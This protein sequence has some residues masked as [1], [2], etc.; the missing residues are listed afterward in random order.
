MFKGLNN[1]ISFEDLSKEEL[2]AFNYI[3]YNLYCRRGVDFTQY[4][5]KCL[6]RRVIV[7]M[8]DANCSSFVDFL[9]Y[10][11]SNPDFYDYLLDRITINVS[12]FFRNPET[13]EYV[14]K[15]VIPDIILRK[16]EIGRFNIRAW[17]AGCAAGEEPYSLAIIF[18]EILDFIKDD[19]TIDIFA[20]DIDRKALE[21]AKLGIYTDNAFRELNPQQIKKYFDKLDGAYIIKPAYKSIVKFSNHDMINQEPLSMIDLIF[22]RNVII[23]FNRELQ[24][25]VYANFQKALVDYGYIVAGKTEGL[26][27]VHEEAFERVDLGE[28]I[29]K[30]K[31][32]KKD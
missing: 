8:H 31:Q 16:K 10:L 6:R 32:T 5:P 23:Y 18:K 7:S 28:R 15:K 14:R 3:L 11:N 9:S 13:F 17:S 19:F 1:F 29:L 25:K 24:K 20:T 26:I 2:Q 4:R 30:K 22:C 27:D 21:K 12:E